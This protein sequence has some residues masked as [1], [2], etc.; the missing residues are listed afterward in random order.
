MDLFALNEKRSRQSVIAKAL[1]F[2]KQVSGQMAIVKPLPLAPLITDIENDIKRSE[3]VPNDNPLELAAVAS[4][5]VTDDRHRKPC[6][7]TERFKAAI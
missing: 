7:N 4:G 5:F 3:N 2:S 6:R 1:L